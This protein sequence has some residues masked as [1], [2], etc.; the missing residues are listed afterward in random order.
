MLSA[1]KHLYLDANSINRISIEVKMLRCAQHDVHARCSAALRLTFMTFTREALLRAR[2]KRGSGYLIATGTSMSA[3]RIAR[4][5]G[6]TSYTSRS[7]K[8]AVLR[9]VTITRRA[10]CF[11]SYS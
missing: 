3:Q 11:A 6:V 10:S 5:F 1:A 2:H 8:A 4:P 9:G 7:V